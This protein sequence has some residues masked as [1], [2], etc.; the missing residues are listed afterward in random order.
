[1][2]VIQG[3]LVRTDLNGNLSTGTDPEPVQTLPDVVV[4]PNPAS[5]LVWVSIK[6]DPVETISWVLYTTD[7]RVAASGRTS[8][9]VF[10]FDVRRLEGGLYVLKFPDTNLKPKRLAIVHR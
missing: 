2:G 8:A 7:G 4:Y 9:P 5:S 3:V 1:L 10:N 6:P